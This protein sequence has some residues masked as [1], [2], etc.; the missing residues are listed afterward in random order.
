MILYI[1]GKTIGGLRRVKMLYTACFFKLED[2][3]GEVFSVAN[4]APKMFKGNT[5]RAFNPPWISVKQLKEKHIEWERFCEIY[6]KH[7]AT[8][9]V[10][11]NRDVQNV[12]DLL[13]DGKDVTLAC[14]EKT[15]D[16]C[17]RK[18]LADW[19]AEKLG[20][21]LDEENIR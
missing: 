12:K 6:E 7:L 1:G 11:S 17:H 3:H 5:L 9:N 15:T 14:W 13:D 19:L 2:Q 4:S 10:E 18:R 8:I 16:R 21:E 20:F